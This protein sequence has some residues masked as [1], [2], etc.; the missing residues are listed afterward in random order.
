[1]PFCVTCTSG[2]DL[3]LEHKKHQHVGNSWNPCPYSIQSSDIRSRAYL[4]AIP[5][6]KNDHTDD[7][8][9]IVYMRPIYKG[10]WGYECTFSGCPYFQFYGTKYFYR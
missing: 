3:E 7:L 2:V 6:G 10:D 9:R 5:A 8:G 4:G 1:M